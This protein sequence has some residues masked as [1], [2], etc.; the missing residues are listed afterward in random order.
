MNTLILLIDFIGH[1][2]LSEN[3]INNRRYQEVQ[4]ILSDPRID[5]SKIIF[6]TT[7]SSRVD[8]RLN[9]LEFMASNLDIKFFKYEDD[10]TFDM[11]SDKLAESF[12]FD[13]NPNNTQIIIGGCN[14]AGC[15]T[16]ATKP[17]NATAACE[18]GY[19]TTIYLPMCAEYEQP[20]INDVERMMMGLVEVYKQIKK[21]RAFKITLENDFRY[22]NLPRTHG[23]L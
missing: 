18:A 13:M 16:K 22:L 23:T 14:L 9:E 19:P 7:D 17:M 4:K 2:V 10:W 5:K 20:G 11:L 12:D 3:Y 21:Y 8:V 15:V 1:Q 6:C